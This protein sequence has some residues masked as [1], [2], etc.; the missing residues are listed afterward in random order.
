MHQELGYIK[1]KKILKKANFLD[2]IPIRKYKHEIDSDGNV[3]ILAPRF[4]GI[5]TRH[6][7]QPRLKNPYI[8]IQLDEA[9]SVT[10]LL[11]DGSSNVRQI[12]QKAYEQLGEKIHPAHDRVT[13]F[14]SGL[15][16]QKFITF[17]EILK[18]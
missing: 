17:N 8:K 15:Y 3:I 13:T 5:I 2:L 10:W 9:G 14:F 6:L 12:C 11:T 4:T 16:M 1:K 7:F 18:S